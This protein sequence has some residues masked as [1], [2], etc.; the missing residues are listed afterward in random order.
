MVKAKVEVINRAGLHARAASKLVELTSSFVS[1]IKIGHEKI[2]DGKSILSLM[3]LAA[4]KGTE[5]TIEV[6]GSDEQEALSAI[7]NLIN[8]RFEE[9]D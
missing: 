9:S 3:M 1:E 6:H 4:T 8:D 5:L 2:V 7:V